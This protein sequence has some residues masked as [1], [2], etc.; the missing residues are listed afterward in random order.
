MDYE[1]EMLDEEMEMNED[2]EFLNDY[3]GFF[4]LDDD[5]CLFQSVDGEVPNG[6][7]FF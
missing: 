2:D 4:S 7:P 1:N 5:V 6:L 3:G